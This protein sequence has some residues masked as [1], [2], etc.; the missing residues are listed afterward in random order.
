MARRTDGNGP[1]ATDGAEQ[2]VGRAVA[3]AVLVVFAAVALRGY[4]PGAEEPARD[5][6]AEN[7]AATGL[8]L[9]LLIASIGIVA[10]A[11]IARLRSRSAPAAGTSGRPDWFRGERSR[12]TWRVLVVAFGVVVAWLLAVMVLNR[13]GATVAV[14]PP[15]AAVPAPTQAVPT[16]SPDRAT[17]AAG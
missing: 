10:V 7:P 17:T 13:L 1:A 15:D 9:G 2:P 16:P 11:V 3:L 4:V 5:R 6:T 14:G 8:V 12:P